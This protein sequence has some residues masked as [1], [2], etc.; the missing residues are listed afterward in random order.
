[1]PGELAFRRPLLGIGPLSSTVKNAQDLD[2]PSANAIWQ[3]VRSAGHHQLPRVGHSTGPS[4]GRIVPH[5][6]HRLPDPL[7]HFASRKR[8][9]FGYVTPHRLKIVDGLVEPPD[10]HSA[11]L[12]S[13][14]LPQ[15]ASQA[16]T[17]SSS[18]N[19]AP[20]SSALLTAA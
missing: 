15:V 14:G 17:F 6:A 1:M 4:C 12:R 16:S 7:R 20:R 2:R 3:N 5:N 13:L 19:L 11:G 10:P 8:V 9:V 18:M